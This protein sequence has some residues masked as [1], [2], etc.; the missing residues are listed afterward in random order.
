M[1]EVV[2]IW[3]SGAS[4]NAR[5]L[6]KLVKRGQRLRVSSHRR[7]CLNGRTPITCHCYSLVKRIIYVRGHK[8]GTALDQ[9]TLQLNEL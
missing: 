7:T 8:A 5:L 3:P 4:E 1:L 6:S 9:L 2:D